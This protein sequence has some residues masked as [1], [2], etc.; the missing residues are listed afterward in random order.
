MADGSPLRVK[1]SVRGNITGG[2]LTYT[3]NIIVADI[4]APAILGLDFLMATRSTVAMEN[5]T[6]GNRK[7]MV[8]LRDRDGLPIV[9]QV[10]VSQTTMNPAGSERILLGEVEYSDGV[11]WS[12]TGVL[13]QTESRKNLQRGVVL[14]RAVV[15][16]G[17]QVPM[18]L[19]NPGVDPVLLYKG[20][21]I[22]RIMPVEAENI[23]DSSS[24]R[25]ISCC[26]MVGSRTHLLERSKEHLTE[27]QG[28]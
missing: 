15:K 1:G 7:Q 3:G 24:E 28:Q 5:M 11:P 10:H 21:T 22:C 16:V 25:L 8:S 23:A 26:R 4:G 27:S 12:E 2:K 19:F 6:L 20:M 17:A 13:E 18:I 14:T 9:R